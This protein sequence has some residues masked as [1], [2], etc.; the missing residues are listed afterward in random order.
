MHNRHRLV[1]VSQVCQ[2]TLTLEGGREEIYATVINVLQRSKRIAQL[3]THKNIHT[4][5]TSIHMHRA[6]AQK[7]QKDAWLTTLINS[8]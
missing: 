1:L 2:Q 6:Y 4:H 5:I 8:T 3:L 7:W